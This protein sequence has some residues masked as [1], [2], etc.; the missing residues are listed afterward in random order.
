MGLGGVEGK[1]KFLKT[2]ISPALTEE[3][4]S[5]QR[6]EGGEIVSQENI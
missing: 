6:L 2:L 5:E 1:L 3:E 4:I